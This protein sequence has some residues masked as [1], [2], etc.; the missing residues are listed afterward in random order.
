MLVLM[1]WLNLTFTLIVAALAPF[2]L[3]FVSRRKQSLKNAA[4]L[5]RLRTYQHECEECRVGKWDIGAALWAPESV[6][7]LSLC[8]MTQSRGRMFRTPKCQAKMTIWKQ[9]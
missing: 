9:P 1:F 4:R 5:M 6:Y 8:R 7:S 2:L 3:R